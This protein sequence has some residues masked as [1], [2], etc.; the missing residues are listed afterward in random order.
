MSVKE[1]MDR[2]AKRAAEDVAAN[3][4][5][6]TII[7]GEDHE[8]KAA[9]AKVASGRFSTAY[10]T[11]NGALVVTRAPGGKL[12]ALQRANDEGDDE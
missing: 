2:D 9:L 1:R 12:H 11:R 10:R 8:L 4:A 6:K 7:E 3:A 5:P